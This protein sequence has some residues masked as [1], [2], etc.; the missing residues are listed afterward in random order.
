MGEWGE[1]NCRNGILGKD[2]FF[3]VLYGTG[4]DFS[5]QNF[6]NGNLWDLLS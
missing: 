1:R 3:R 6:K 4:R 2:T 5:V